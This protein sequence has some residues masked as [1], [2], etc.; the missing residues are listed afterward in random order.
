M[1]SNKKEPKI[2]VVIPAYNE[3]KYITKTLESLKKQISPPFEIIVVDNNSGDRTKEIAKS[4]GVKVIIEKIK[5]T[6]AARKKGFENAS[7]EIIATTDADT[8]L[9]PN[10]LYKIKEA[11]LKNPE[12]IAVGGP[13]RFDSKKYKIFVEFFAWIWIFLDKIF[14][15]GNNIPG[16]NMAVL[17]SAYKKV[18]GFKN[19]GYEDLDL[20][21]RLKKYGKVLFLKDL[22]VITSFRRYAQKGF[23]K[24]VWKYMKNYYKMRFRNKNVYME[25]IREKNEE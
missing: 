17:K 15:K 19:C 12:I 11:F 22:L 21:L 20:S 14:N 4:F 9:P 7:G 25:D 23:F 5:G 2:S 24:T 10:W 18:G 13:Y 16:V 8:I 3:E 6:G 1:I